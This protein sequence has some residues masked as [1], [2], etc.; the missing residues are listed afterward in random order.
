[1]SGAAIAPDDVV[2]RAS[3]VPAGARAPL[4]VL[5]PLEAF[6]DAH[7]LGAGPIAAEPIGE[8]HS[9]VTYL[10]RREQAPEMILRR[11]PRPPV[12]PSAHDVLREARVL[13]ALWPTAA[14]VPRVLATC[15]DE[16]LIGAPFY[17]MERV[18]GEVIVSSVP[19]ALDRPE[20]RRRI[21]EELIDALIEIHA[22]PWQEVGLEGFGKP[23]GYL[24]RQL[25]RF[26]GLWEINKTRELASIERVG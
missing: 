5:D 19:A 23:T 7:A 4:V 15:A 24:E 12:P 21:G 11:P 18:P 2:R 10:I 14:R 6:L 17:I 1:M 3:D 20:E 26:G 8:G 9:N 16:S 25:R 22:V 13:S